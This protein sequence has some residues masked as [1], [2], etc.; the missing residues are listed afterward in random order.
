M[1]DVDLVTPHAT[2]NAALE[3]PAGEGPWPGVVVVHDA[4][5]LSRDIRNITRRVADAGFLAMAPNLY[6]GGGPVYCVKTLMREVLARRGPAVDDLLAARDALLD[7]DDCNGR[8]GIVGFCLGGGFALAL[9][10]MGFAASAPFYPSV[11]P[12]YDKLTEGACPI[13]ASFGARDPANIGSGRRLRHHLERKGIPH[14]IKIYPGVGHSFANEQ[15]GQPVLRVTG[16]GY[17]E[18][19]TNDAFGRV[20]AF[21]DEHLR[22]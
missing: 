20:F 1:P 13:V 2:L 11:L 7:R 3:V 18:A 17:D 5:G 10:P 16:F 19:A 22:S 6:A 21:F 9:S 4:A 14:D 12:M 15:P 8:V